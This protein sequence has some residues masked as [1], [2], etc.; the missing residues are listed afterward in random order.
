VNAS[1]AG[2]ER[3]E[4]ITQGSLSTENGTPVAGQPVEISIRGTAITT[5]RTDRT[6]RFNTTIEVPSRFLPATVGGEAEIRITATYANDETNLADTT[7]TSGVVF[8]AE[9]LN[10]VGQNLSWSRTLAAFLVLGSAVALRRRYDRAR[11]EAVPD[12]VTEASRDGPGATAEETSESVS[13]LAL[14][15]RWLGAGRTS[16]AVQFA[17]AAARTRFV[18]VYD[19]SPKKTHWEFYQTCRAVSGEDLQDFERLTALYERAAFA[20]RPIERST[21][22]EAYLLAEAVREALAAETAAGIETQAADDATPRESGEGQ[23]PD[24]EDDDSWLRG[25]NDSRSDGEND[26]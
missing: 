25:D 23:G 17:Y 26:D 5:V 6:G 14:A 16:A 24:G 4:V 7:T 8:Q 2:P 15:D 9:L 19:V 12:T 3:R 13:L 10:V 22:E 18:E 21:A 11:M 1:T 20:D